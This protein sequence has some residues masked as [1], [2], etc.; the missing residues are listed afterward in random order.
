MKKIILCLIAASIF[1]IPADAVS[2]ATSRATSVAINDKARADR[3]AIMPKLQAL[4]NAASLEEA[5]KIKGELMALLAARHSALDLK[6]EYIALEVGMAEAEFHTLSNQT[7]AK[8]Q[9]MRAEAKE[10]AEEN[11]KLLE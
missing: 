2:G 7:L 11:W 4:A 3:Q 8:K 5:R 9:A 1:S 10:R 6:A